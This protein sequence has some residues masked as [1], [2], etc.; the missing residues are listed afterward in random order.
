M[1][2]I[3]IY[4]IL[5]Y[6]NSLSEIQGSNKNIDENQAL[7]LTTETGK[8]GYELGEACRGKHS[9][10]WYKMFR[11]LPDCKACSASSTVRIKWISL[12]PSNLLG[13]VPV[14]VRHNLSSEYYAAKSRRTRCAHSVSSIVVPE[15]SRK[16]S[17][18]AGWKSFAEKIRVFETSV[19]HVSNNRWNQLLCA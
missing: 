3:H 4:I 18:Y 10:V 13:A 2:Y 5:P 14:R 9:Y 8:Y 1:K 16:L 11:R 7:N 6:P 12:G 15:S 17:V 19:L